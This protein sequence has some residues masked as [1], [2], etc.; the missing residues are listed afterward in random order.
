MCNEYTVCL[1]FGKDDC[2]ERTEEIAHKNNAV[3]W[4]VEPVIAP[5]SLQLAY[6]GKIVKEVM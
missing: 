2:E 3:N 1:C 4:F 5:L 6:R